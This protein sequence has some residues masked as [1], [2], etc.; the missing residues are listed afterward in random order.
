[1][2]DSVWGGELKNN[3]YLTP[4]KPILDILK[5]RQNLAAHVKIWD[6]PKI[7]VKKKRILFSVV[8][9]LNLYFEKKYF[10]IHAICKKSI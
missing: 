5:K 8:K 2:F 6:V 9:L 1:M 10:I 3:F 4:T 7:S